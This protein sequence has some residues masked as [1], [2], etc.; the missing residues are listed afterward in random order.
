MTNAA[1][2]NK[3]V[4]LE[5]EIQLLKKS[6]VKQPDFTVDEVNWQKIRPALKKARGKLA[7]R[8]YG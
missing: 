4:N 3:I 8:L 2:K 5:A 7:K 6:V 1:V